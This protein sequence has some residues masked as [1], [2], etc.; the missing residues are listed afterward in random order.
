MAYT[1]ATS[2]LTTVQQVVDLTGVQDIKNLEEDGE[3]IAVDNLKAA[4][5]W[6]F[7]RIEQR[8]GA[9]DVL[10][11]TNETR[12]ERA[13]AARFLEVLF[14]GPLRP[15][16]ELRD[17]WQAQAADESDRFRAE[18]SSGD[19]SRQSSEGVPEFGH[20]EEGWVYGPLRHRTSNQKLSDWIPDDR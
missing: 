18:L 6:V 1:R 12:L 10:L 19:E 3:Y 13:V 11:I 2:I 20:F 16:A 5:V 7:D 17:Y 9:T 8:L 4:H 14:A 15:D